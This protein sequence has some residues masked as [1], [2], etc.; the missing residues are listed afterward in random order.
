[1]EGEAEGV[2]FGEEV[3]EPV[4]VGGYVVRFLGCQVGKEGLQGFG[5]D[6][7]FG[8]GGGE[9]DRGGEWSWVC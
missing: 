7:G 3:G 2:A 1:M 9:G 8:V 4:D 6:E 5:E